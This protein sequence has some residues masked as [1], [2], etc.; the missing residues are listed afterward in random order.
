MNKNRN[1]ISHCFAVFGA[2]GYI[3]SNLVHYLKTQHQEVI[4]FDLPENDVLSHE[5]WNSFR[6]ELFN[7]VYFLCGMSGVEPSFQNPAKFI[8][9]NQIGL[10]NLLEKIKTLG[11]YAPKIIFPSSRLVYKGGGRVT[12]ESPIYCRS[13]Y[14]ATKVAC[15]GLLTAYHAR[16]QIPF[17][18]LRICLPFGT[19][20]SGAP[21]SYGTISFFEKQAKSSGCIT[22]YG[23]GHGLRTFTHI[24]S[25]CELMFALAET[26]KVGVFNAGGE[27]LTMREAAVRV[28]K[29]YK[30][31]VKSVPWPEYALRVESPGVIFDDTK[32]RTLLSLKFCLHR[33]VN[34]IKLLVR[35]LKKNNND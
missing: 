10:L 5:F 3:G 33:K 1:R 2:K 20:L 28:A 14:A 23:D 25:I 31:L 22:L 30:A 18:V 34:P 26:A 7:G 16:Y 21:C 27:T 8:E 12:E 15:E 4:E 24:K 13:V 17:A 6:P 35:K 19:L 32:I 11:K 29:K 9:V